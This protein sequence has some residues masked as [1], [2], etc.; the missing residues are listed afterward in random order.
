MTTEKNSIPSQNDKIMAA[1]A[2][3]SAVLPFM[4]VIAPIVIW[5]TQKDKSEYV[6]F[7]ALQAVAYQLLM[8]FAWFVGM[9][10]YMLSFFSMFL[11]IPLAGANGGRVD[12]SIAPLFALGFMI[13]FV[14]FGAIFV[15][16]ALFV[17]YGIIGAVQVFQGKDFRYAIIGNR[18]MNY[19]NT[20]NERTTL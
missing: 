4:G 10:C 6:A 16:G 14:I 15:G 8:I 18:L 20:N 5:A 7:Q 17:I 2:H 3:I 11:G 1:L 12:P 19:L 9:G 13:P